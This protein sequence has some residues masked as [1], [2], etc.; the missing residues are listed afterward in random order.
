MSQPTP[1]EPLGI[2][3]SGA[4][5]CGLAKV[6]GRAT[7]WAR[8]ED[9]AE[10][11]RAKLPSE[12]E[13]TT[14]LEDL[15]E[16]GIVIETVAEELGVKQPL[17]SEVNDYLRADALLATSTS[18]LDVQALA[19]ASGRPD[20]FAAF[21]V[22]NPVQRME[23]IELAFPDQAVPDTRRRMHALCE[24]I[25]KTAVEVPCVPGFVVNRLLFP[26]L[27][28]AVELME[29]QGLEPDAVDTCMHLGAHHPIGPLG[30]LD[31]VGLD[32]SVAIA[33]AI[34]IEVPARVR[35]MVAE[36]KLGRKSG[37]GFYRYD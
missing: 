18:S 25:G 37:A 34:G 36:G 32:I 35:E 4:I 15:A 8:S 29:A 1:F 16:C 2:V 11:A 19:D 17:L 5:A 22:F 23:L 27:F 20:R 12:V 30:L 6:A 9:S 21:H 26:Y 14:E 33:D 24:S 28:S 7:V 13:V 3:G 10:R 31:L